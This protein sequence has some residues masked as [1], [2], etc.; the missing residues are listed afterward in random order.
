MADETMTTDAPEASTVS[1]WDVLGPLA[2]DEEM[3]TA[4]VPPAYEAEPVKGALRAVGDMVLASVALAGRYNP[5]QRQAEVDAEMKAFNQQAYVQGVLVLPP[6][7]IKAKEAQIRAAQRRTSEEAA[8]QYEAQRLIAARVLTTAIEA[9]VE[10]PTHAASLPAN[11][12]RT[13]RLLAQLLD[14][15][16]DSQ[17]DRWRSESPRQWLERY[18]RTD[19]GAQRA[20]VRAVERGDVPVR[21]ADDGGSVSRDL[22]ALRELRHQVAQ[23]RAARV[24]ADLLQAVSVFRG[25]STADRRM[26]ARLI[27]RGDVE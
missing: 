15:H 18:Q 21:V 17:V 16:E 25:E 12:S 27:L 26:K 9:A 8:R 14:V 2:S 6:D 20:F 13:D 10:V 22:A 24:P 7:A 3:A 1:V 5:A 11:A 23:R 4:T 19:D